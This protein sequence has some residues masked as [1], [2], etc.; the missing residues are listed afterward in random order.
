MMSY[1][2]SIGEPGVPPML[3]SGEFRSARDAP[4]ILSKGS[5]PML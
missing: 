1:Y 4:S 5:V 2:P 3:D